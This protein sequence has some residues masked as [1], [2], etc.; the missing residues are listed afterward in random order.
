MRS[1][2]LSTLAVVAALILAGV[3]AVTA[4]TAQHATITVERD[5]DGEVELP[6]PDRTSQST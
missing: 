1:S 4:S 5:A 2:K 6:A 3:A